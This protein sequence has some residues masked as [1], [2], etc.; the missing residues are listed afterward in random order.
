MPLAAAC[1]A[2]ILVGASVV[3]V[4]AVTP[5]VEPA[6][7]AFMR[8]GGAAF[9]MLLILFLWP[10]L[11]P[12][13]IALRDLPVVAL[14]GVMQFAIFYLFFNHGIRYITA[15]RAALVISLIPFVTM[16][17]AA[18]RGIERLTWRKSL[19]VAL[20]IAGVATALAPRIVSEGAGEMVWL[21]ALLVFCSVCTGSSYNVISPPYLARIPASSFT[22]ASLA[23]GSLVLAPF[24]AAEG[25]FAAWP[26]LSLTG[27]LC[28]LFLAG[29]AGFG[30][31]LLF[32]WALNRTSPTGVTV[33]L[34]LAPITAV[35][36]GVLL[37]GEP[38]SLELIVGLVL[39]LAGLYTA[40]RRPT[41]RAEGV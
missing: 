4:R 25:F 41:D 8:Y 29:P 16:S 37:L 32:N 14:L 34:S 3:A 10:G 23:A 27:W 2:G 9:A 30:S 19:G 40:S 15:S 1:L 22:A 33:F 20:T 13:R 5:E 26:E 6:G 18:L 36:L 17:L 39:V 28:V 11:P 31:I 7:L 24:A 12:F 21:G 38:L 35:G